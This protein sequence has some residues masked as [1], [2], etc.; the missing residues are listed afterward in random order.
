[1]SLN[2]PLGPP[3]ICNAPRVVDEYVDLSERRD[4]IPDHR[5]AVIVFSNVAGVDLRLHAVFRASRG[6][7]LRALRVLVA[8]DADVRALVTREC[9][10]TACADAMRRAGDQDVP[11]HV[12][13]PFARIL[14][15]LVPFRNRKAHHS[16][17]ITM[18]ALP[19]ETGR[20]GR[21]RRAGSRRLLSARP[22]PSETQG[23]CSPSPPSAA[24]RRPYHSRLRRP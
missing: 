15:H 17:F 21:A 24:S 23:R 13:N 5:L 3:G 1:M 16:R 11:S 12:P 4:E 7:L 19:G 10:G 20:T 6:D 18:C 22:I 14:Y 9:D 8:R 2:S